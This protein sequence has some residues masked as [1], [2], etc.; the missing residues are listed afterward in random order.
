MP[1]TTIT[2][3]GLIFRRQYIL[4]V[5][6]LISNGQRYHYIGQTGHRKHTT[7]RPPFRR[8]AGHLENIGQSTQNQLY[9]YIA[10]DILGIPT[11]RRQETFP[12]DVK[13]QVE[14]FLVNSVVHMHAY[15]LE[16]FTPRVRH[17]E[18]LRVQRKV[19]EFER[20]VLRKFNEA[21]LQIGNRS[22]HPPNSMEPPYPEVLDE[23]VRDF[24]LNVTQR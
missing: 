3:D 22:I 11:A 16:P 24:A 20:H 9:R 8:L 12:S 19:E 21:G 18:H 6:E 2:L 17:E 14:D 10:A 23:I 4:Y 1:R 7:A 15:T 5:I 13:Q